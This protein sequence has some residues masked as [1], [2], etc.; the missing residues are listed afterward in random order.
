MQLKSADADLASQEL[1]PLQLSEQPA[2]EQLTARRGAE[3]ALVEAQNR[4]AQLDHALQQGG[5]PTTSAGHV[6]DTRVLGRPDMTGAESST[7]G[8][9]CAVVFRL[10]HVVHWQSSGPHRK[11]SSRLEHGGVANALSG[12]FPKE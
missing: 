6:V 1:Q 2:A 9:E 10:D 11:C 12:V 7:E 4:I 3:H 5:R 8:N